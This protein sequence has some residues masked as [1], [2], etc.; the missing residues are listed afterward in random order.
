VRDFLGVVSTGQTSTDPRRLDGAWEPKSPHST[1]M[2]RATLLLT[3][4]MRCQVNNRLHDG[5][6]KEILGSRICPVKTGTF[7]PLR[8]AADAQSLVG[9]VAALRAPA[10]EAGA[11]RRENW[12]TGR[13]LSIHDPFIRMSQG[14]PDNLNKLPESCNFPQL[15]CKQAQSISTEQDGRLPGWN[16][17]SQ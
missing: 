2:L 6:F 1:S 5:Y 7:F 13:G 16:L 17:G 11:S 3:S 4:T 8:G 9:R 14:P 15:R 12:S 10:H